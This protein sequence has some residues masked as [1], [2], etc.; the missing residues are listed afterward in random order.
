LK[1]IKGQT[2]RGRGGKYTDLGS[3]EKTQTLLSQTHIM[4]G[5]QRECRAP[6]NVLLMVGIARKKRD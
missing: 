1:I 5:D 6:A 4:R 3:P 2:A